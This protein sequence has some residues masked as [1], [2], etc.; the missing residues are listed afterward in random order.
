MRE[1]ILLSFQVLIGYSSVGENLKR[2]NTLN[3]EDLE[4]FKLILAEK[5]SY[6]K[7]SINS[8]LFSPKY[9]FLFQVLEIVLNTCRS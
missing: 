4:I 2:M 1:I 5:T 3:F 8:I 6:L 9:N 7:L